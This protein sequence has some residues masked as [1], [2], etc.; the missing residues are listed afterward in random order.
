METLHLLRSESDVEVRSLIQGIGG[1]D[2]CS[3]LLLF[4]DSV[5]YDRVIAAMFEHDRVISRR[6]PAGTQATGPGQKGWIG[7]R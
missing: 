6:Q 5:D 1:A 4:G 3:I 2:D 7:P